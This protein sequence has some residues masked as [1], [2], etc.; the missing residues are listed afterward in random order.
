MHCAYDQPGRFQFPNSL[1]KDSSAD[2]RDRF[3][4]IAEEKFPPA[5]RKQDRPHPLLREEGKC[6]IYLRTGRRFYNFHKYNLIYCIDYM[7]EYY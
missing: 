3:L 7:Q 5:Q 4:E 1:G 6:S 2:A